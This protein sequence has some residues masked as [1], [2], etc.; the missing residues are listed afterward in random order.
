MIECKDGLFHLKNHALS[1]LLRVNRYG[2]LEQV[3]FGAPV[4]SEDVEALA[5]Q[6]GLGWGS[7]LLLNDRDPGSNPDAMALA[8]SGSGR[9]DFR[10]SPMEMDGHSTN[11]TYVNH[12]ILDAAPVLE[13]GLPQTH[14][15]GET[16]E[17]LM[18]QPGARLKL[19]FTLYETA[20]TRFAVLENTGE[21][22]IELHKLMSFS[23]DIYGSYTMTTFNGGWAAEMQRCDTVVGA[24]RVVNESATGAS[25]NVIMAMM[26]IMLVVPVFIYA[27]LLVLRLK[28]RNKEEAEQ[29]RDKQS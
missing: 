4:R 24:S 21:Q 18:E 14:G 26:F 5:G 8:W 12:R 16:L 28:D 25:S 27:F 9:G 2:L 1:C 15:K 13:S 11:F 7:S 10:E 17:I 23:M 20:M 3:H 19:Y 6:P 22:P 29:N